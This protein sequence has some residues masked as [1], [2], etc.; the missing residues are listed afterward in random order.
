MKYLCRMMI[1]TN[2]ISVQTAVI[3]SMMIAFWSRVVLSLNIVRL[4]FVFFQSPKGM[5]DGKDHCSIRF[6]LSSSY[7]TWLFFMAIQIASYAQLVAT[8]VLNIY[9]I[10]KHTIQWPVVMLVWII[11]V[12]I[13]ISRS[14]M[15]CI[16]KSV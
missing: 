5:V 7:H 2:K 8:S 9:L 11:C 6:V 13:R 14:L 12:Y 10:E 16:N 15:L 4:K 3:C 1:M